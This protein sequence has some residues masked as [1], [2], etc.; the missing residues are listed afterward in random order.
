MDQ[1]IKKDPN[2]KMD[3][4]EFY[5]MKFIMNA[6]QEGWSVKKSEDTYIFTMKHNGKKE[7]YKEEYLEDF[8]NRNICLN[9]KNN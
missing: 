4:K 9:N 1:N 2:I 5:K 7:I 8:I 6:L 3:R